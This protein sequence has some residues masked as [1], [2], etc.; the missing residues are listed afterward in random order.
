[1]PEHIDYPQSLLLR[2]SRRESSLQ[3]LNLSGLNVCTQGLLVQT[4][5]AI[6]SCACLHVLIPI[7]LGLFS[8]ERSQRQFHGSRYV[9]AIVTIQAHTDQLDRVMAGQVSILC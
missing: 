2:G 9:I 1:M 3:L 5:V 7:V 6:D 4:Q 8:T